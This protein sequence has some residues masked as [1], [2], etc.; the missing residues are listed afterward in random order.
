V[1]STAIGDRLRAEVPGS[2]RGAVLARGRLYYAAAAGLLQAARHGGTPF[3]I[4]H[5]TTFF[6]HLHAH[7]AES[8]SFQASMAA[9]AAG[10]AAAVVAAYDFARFTDLVDVGGGTGVLLAAIREAAPGLDAVLFD[11]PEVVAGCAQPAVGGDFFT[12]VPAGAQAYLL[13]RVIHDWPDPDAVAILTTCR[14]A[15]PPQ[16][17]LLLVE[18]V[19]PQRAAADPAAIRMDLHMLTLLGGRERTVTEFTGLL[20]AAKL[21]LTAVIPA[22]PASGVHVLEARHRSGGKAAG[23]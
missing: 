19:L 7:P 21:Y 4:V 14:R 8:A 1:Y 18:A 13:S 5:G 6:D 11:R 22:D 23:R 10:E 2:M 15:M 3:E 20:D 9:R 17:V 16:G 12:E